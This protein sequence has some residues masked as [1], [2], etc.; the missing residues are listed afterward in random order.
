MPYR[1]ETHLH[2]SQGSGCGHSTG[3]EMVRLYKEMGYQGIIVTDHFFRGNT[4]VPRDLPWKERIERFFEGYE[5]AK[6]EGERCGLDVF[7]G[8]EQRFTSDEFLVYGLDKQWLL[9]H[10]EMEAWTRKDQLKQVHLAGGCVVQP[11]PFRDRDY[12]RQILLGLQFADAIEVANSCN[13]PYNDAYALRYAREFNLFVTAGSD[14]HWAE[15]P[16]WQ[17]GLLMGI[18]V[19][20]PLKSIHDYV[21]LIRQRGPIRPIIQP[22]RFDVNPSEAPDLETFWFDDEEKP[23]PTGRHWLMEKE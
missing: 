13:M 3:R 18:E 10:P 7:F 21:R 8:W 19:D 4:A 16:K 14:N 22:G 17:E 2:T 12:I 20:E 5:D 6:A 9:N 23:V 1:Y 15:D 11:H